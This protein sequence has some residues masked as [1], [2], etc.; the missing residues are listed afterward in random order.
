MRLLVTGSQGQIGRELLQAH[1]PS[2]LE[3]V[4]LPRRRLDITRPQQVAAALD[5]AD[6]ELVVNAAAFTEVDRAET[7]PKAAFAANCE[8][9]ALLADACAERDIPLIHI[10][11]DYVFDGRKPSAYV[12]DD[13]VCP[14]NAYGASKAAGERAV[15][16]RWPRHV[17]LRTSWVYSAHGANFVKT[18]LRLG[19]EKTELAIVADQVGGPTAAGDI[20]AAILAIAAH[21]ASGADGH[22]GVFHY[23]GGGETS[24]Y[25]FA[26]RIFDFQEKVAGRRPRLRKICAAERPSPARRPANS[27]LDCA[28]IAGVYGIRLVPWEV[29]VDRVLSDLTDFALRGEN[30]C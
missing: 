15:I 5:N 18:M 7:E 21:V 29:A 26:E 3:L 25:G 11:T 22:W 30:S 23:S 2:G 10:S 12:E 16:D 24:W 14:I 9:P 19:L 20:A 27:R 28:K 6:A 13:P 8:G 17:I 4:G 1:L